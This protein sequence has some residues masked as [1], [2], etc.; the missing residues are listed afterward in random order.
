MVKFCT[1]TTCILLKADENGIV[2]FD[3]AP[4]AYHVQL[5]KVPDGYSFDADFEMT[6]DAAYSEWVIT[7]HSRMNSK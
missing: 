3:G 1:D 2:S 7:I 5:L 6:T 4:D